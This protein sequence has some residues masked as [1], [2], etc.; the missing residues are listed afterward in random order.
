M[1]EGREAEERGILRHKKTRETTR[2]KF[3]AEERG[4]KSINISRKS[5]SG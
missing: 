4:T 3:R 2:M 1:L 5:G